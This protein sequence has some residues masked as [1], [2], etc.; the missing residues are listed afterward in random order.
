MCDLKHVTYLMAYG[1]FDGTRNREREGNEDLFAHDSLVSR[2]SLTHFYLLASSVYINKLI[3]SFTMRWEMKTM[4]YTS[5]Y[6]ARHAIFLG[7]I[8]STPPMCIQVETSSEYFH[9][10]SLLLR[11]TLTNLPCYSTCYGTQIFEPEW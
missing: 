6:I 3:N 10:S 4:M 2:H 11:T 5:R 7:N 9:A 8:F 1:P